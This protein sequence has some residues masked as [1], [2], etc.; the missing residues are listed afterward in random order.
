MAKIKIYTTDSCPW[1][2]RAKRIFEELRIEFEEINIRG[3]SAMRKELEVLTGRRDV[4]QIF[5][6]NQHIGDDDD[7]V[8]LVQSGQLEERFQTKG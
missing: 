1:C 3:S 8:E 4:P 5:I 6:N 7:L 2:D